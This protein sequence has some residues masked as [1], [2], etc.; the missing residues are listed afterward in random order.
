VEVLIVLLALGGVAWWFARRGVGSGS[1][2]SAPAPRSSERPVPRARPPTFPH[3][4]AKSGARWVPLHETVSVSGLTLPGGVYVGDALD[5]VSGWR[6]TEPALID[7][8]QPVNLRRPDVGGQ[9]MGYWPSYTEIPPASRGAYLK[10]LE[11]LRPGGAYI[12]YVFLFF[13]GI[14]RRVI[15]DAATSISARDEIPALLAEVERLLALYGDN[16]SFSGYATDFLATARLAGEPKAVADLT[17]PRERAGWD[18]PL[19]VRLAAGA[20]A[21]AGEPL[22][23]EWALAWAL[24]SPQIGLRTPATRCPEEFADLFL[25]R[26]AAQHGDGLLIKPNKTKLRLQYRPASAS[27][28]GAIDLDAGD[29]PDVT[30]LS[31]PTNK[32]ATLVAAVTDELDAYSRYVGRHDDRTSARAV[33]LLPSELARHRVPAEV[34]PLVEDLPADGHQVVPASRLAEVLGPRE[35]AK[36]PKRDA[37][38]VASLLATHGVGVEPDVRVGA[39]N[40]SHGS[41][42]VLWREPAAAAPVG[43]GFAAA[44]VLLHLGVTVGASDDEVSPAEQ[45]HLEAG[46]ERAFDLPDAG[47]RRLRAHLRWLLAERPGIAG[48]KTRIGALQPSQRELIAR[49]LVAVAGADG[50]VSPREVDS[51]RR[52]Y[53]LLGL[54]PEGVHRDLHGLAAGPSLG[55]VSVVVAD[56]DR[57]DFAIPG[58]VLLDQRRLADVLSSTRQVAEVLTA[59]FV[60]DEPPTEEPAAT[61]APGDSA[62]SDG[63]PA[64]RGAVAGLDAAHA[65]L[66][67]RLAA[68]PTWSR[69]DFDALAEELGLLGAGAIE[70][71]NGAAFMHSDGPLLEGDDPIELDGYVLKELLHA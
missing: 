68:Q 46:L 29:L 67:R 47:R 61:D 62:D 15:R 11:A 26:Y 1:T 42:A 66:V 58:E 9:Q 33:A 60:P 14:E 4:A 71:V 24:H 70:T 64:D 25:A 22:P 37:V 16:G 23:G 40:F 27:F 38:A 50:H 17:P 6:G 49:Y 18:I 53:G 20:L 65:T 30:R 34:R 7:P 36:L 69:P 56:T 43:E 54:D 10:W 3:R 5:A 2:T 12:G 39:T 35:A 52:L 31:G 48:V 59:V 41:H 45:E 63:Y 55:P 32:L 51:L 57:G 21:A 44:T 28:G 13:Y 8:R 19:D